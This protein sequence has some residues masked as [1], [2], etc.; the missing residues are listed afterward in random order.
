MKQKAFIA[1]SAALIAT[2]ACKTA[3]GTATSAA[4]LNTLTPQEQQAGWK[5]LFDGKT[6]SGWRNYKKQD[7]NPAWTVADGILM[8]T[9]EHAGDLITVDKYR[10]FELAFDW[11]VPE[12]GNSGVMYRASEDNDYIWQSGPEFQLLDNERHPDGKREETSAGSVFDVYPAPHSATHPAGEWNS[13]RIVVNGNHV[14]H[15]MNGQK[16][17]EYELGSADWQ[18]RVAASK[19]K[20]TPTYGKSPEGYIGLQGDHD[21]VQFRNIRVRVLP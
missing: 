18:A 15:W 2:T 16:V 7:V 20:N 21:K 8:R 6:T 1:L 3:S 19:W 11:K 4:A 5:L 17:V 12:G 10:N 9:G 14:E 13:S